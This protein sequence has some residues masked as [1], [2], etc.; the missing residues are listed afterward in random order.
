MPK[1]PVRAIALGGSQMY[2][3]RVAKFITE[4]LRESAFSWEVLP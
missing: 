2:T 4:S 1:S 3:R